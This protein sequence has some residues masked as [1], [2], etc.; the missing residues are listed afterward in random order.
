MSRLTVLHIN[1]IGAVV[2]VIVGVALYFVL[3]PPAKET[4]KKNEDTYNSVKAVA[5]TLP[6]EIA[7]AEKAR[8][9]KAAAEAQYH[10]YEAQY[11]PVIGYNKDRMKTMMRIFWPNHGRSWPERFLHGVRGFMASERKRNGIVWEN[12]GVITLGPYGPDPNTIEAGEP[13]EGL[14]RV[15][16]YSFPVSVRAKSLQQVLRH[17]VSWSAVRGIGVPVVEGLN[18]TGNSPRLQATYTVSLTIILHDNE[19]IPATNPR[20]AGSSAAGGGGMRGMGSM[21]GPMMGSAGMGTMTMPGGTMG[22]PGMMGRPSGPMGSSMMSP[23]M[24]SP[25]MS[26]GGKRMPGAAGPTGF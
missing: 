7:D 20:I 19:Q 25:G 10:V 2:A 3:I 26:G 15:L 11:M 17:I 16:R 14:G 9:D 22:S 23:G 8:S 18:V 4:V 13:G 24:M 12:P 1:I 5:D 21:G 6:T